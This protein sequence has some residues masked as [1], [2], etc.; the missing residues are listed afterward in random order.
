MATKTMTIPLCLI[1]LSFGVSSTT[2]T[3]SYA[4][5]IDPKS[6]KLN[7]KQHQKL[8]HL[9]LYWHD[10]VSGAKPSSVAVLPPRNN[11]TE[12]GQVNMFDNPLTAGPEL[13]SQLVGQSQGF[14][15]GAA[16]DQIGL[17]MA[18]NFAFTHGKYKG[19]SF[20]VL[21]RNPISDGVREMPVVGGSGKFRFGSGYALAKTHYLDPV[22]FDA[23]VEYNVYVL[24]Y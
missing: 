9:H 14:Y 4:K 16:Q 7:N 15:A 3:K 23:V 5:D 20:T 8:T 24:H 11:V 13:G 2:A 22:T 1:L 10:T 18:M 19:S 12:F 17:L 21:G 6:L